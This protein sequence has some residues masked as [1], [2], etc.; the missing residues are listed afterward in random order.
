M[1]IKI[2]CPKR[3]RLEIPSENADFDRMGQKFWSFDRDQVFLIVG[4]SGFKKFVQALEIPPLPPPPKKH[5]HLCADIQEPKVQTSMAPGGSTTLVRKHLAN[6]SLF[7]ATHLQSSVIADEANI[8]LSPWQA[9]MSNGILMRTRHKQRCATFV[10][11]TIKRDRVK[12]PRHGQHPDQKIRT[13]S[14]RDRHLYILRPLRDKTG[15]AFWSA[16][17][18]EHLKKTRYTPE[19]RDQHEFR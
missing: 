13:R 9:H 10:W 5:K 7:N 8:R 15:K 2:Q 19:K 14:E 12:N 18:L 16:S 6:F 4:P 11:N 1:N 3:S 17:V